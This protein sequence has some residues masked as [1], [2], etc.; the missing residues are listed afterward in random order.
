M[1]RVAGAQRNKHIRIHMCNPSKHPD[2]IFYTEEQKNLFDSVSL[3]FSA[4]SSVE[5]PTSVEFKVL[6]HSGTQ[7]RSK[8]SLV[9][10]I[11]NE[12]AVLCYFHCPVS[13]SEIFHTKILQIKQCCNHLP[14]S[15]V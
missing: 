3:C 4:F 10:I 14:F 7:L 8:R 13:S 1:S 2:F 15:L 6:Y 5:T 9:L 12:A 11:I